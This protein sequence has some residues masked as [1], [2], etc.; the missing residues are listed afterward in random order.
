MDRLTLLTDGQ[1]RKRDRY[2]SVLSEW[3]TNVG[4]DRYLER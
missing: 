3:Q 4:M 2:Q 1:R